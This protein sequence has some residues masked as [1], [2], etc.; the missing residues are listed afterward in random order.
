MWKS[1]LLILWNIYSTF[2]Q[3]SLQISN[4]F[5]KSFRNLPK[6]LRKHARGAHAIFHLCAN[7]SQFHSIH[8]WNTLILN[9]VT[10]NLQNIFQIS[11][12]DIS[13]ANIWFLDKN[14]LFACLML[15][16]SVL[17]WLGVCVASDRV[18]C[19]GDWRVLLKLTQNSKLM[20]MRLELSLAK[21]I[22]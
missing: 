8:A 21:C 12:P 14:S 17:L 11:F 4:N 3:L 13:L 10:L 7:A 2:F 16:L 18:G 20:L 19:F 6:F 15:R 1:S 9:I 22:K 5:H